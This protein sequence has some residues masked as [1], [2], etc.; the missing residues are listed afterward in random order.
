MNTYKNLRLYLS[1]TFKKSKMLSKIEHLRFFMNTDHDLYEFT[2]GFDKIKYPVTRPFPS[3]IIKDL[4]KTYVP[5][6]S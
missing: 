2:A 1:I 3:K 6:H 5:S 4:M